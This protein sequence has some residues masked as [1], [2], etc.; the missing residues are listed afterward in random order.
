MVFQVKRRNDQHVQ[1]S[2]FPALSDTKVVGGNL[3]IRFAASYA[4][5]RVA[6][7]T[8]CRSVSTFGVFS[9]M[10]Q[11]SSL[12]TWAVAAVVNN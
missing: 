10:L 8:L 9:T 6:S 2:A 5:P 1:T 7:L 12:R 3:G 4:A 11:N